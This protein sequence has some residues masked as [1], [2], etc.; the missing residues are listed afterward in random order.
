MLMQDRGER[1]YDSGSG[2]L[3]FRMLVGAKKAGSVIGKVHRHCR[4][5]SHTAVCRLAPLQSRTE[6]NKGG[7]LM[8]AVCS[9]VVLRQGGDFIQLTRKMTGAKVAVDKPVG[10][11]EDRLVHVERPDE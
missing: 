1:R 7:R 3:H 11:A 6:H 5:P 4:P 10:W 8:H 9:A 2:Q